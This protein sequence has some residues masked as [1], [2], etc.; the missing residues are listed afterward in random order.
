[1]IAQRP[2]LI[3]LL[4]VALV[5]TN[6]ASPPAQPDQRLILYDWAEDMPQSVLDKIEI[7]ET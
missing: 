5:L 3:L 4:S 2:V 7:D 6:C 1:M